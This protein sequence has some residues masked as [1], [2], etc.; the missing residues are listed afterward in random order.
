[1]NAVSKKKK[2]A[3]EPVALRSLLACIFLHGFS[4]FRWYQTLV[5]WFLILCFGVL[6]S[7]Y[8][9]YYVV[10]VPKQE[11]LK[12]YEGLVQVDGKVHY[13]RTGRLKPPRFYLDTANGK[14]PFHCGFIT[15]PEDCWVLGFT[16]E[17]SD[18][19]VRIAYDHYFGVLAVTYPEKYKKLKDGGKYEVITSDFLEWAVKHHATYLYMPFLFV[20]IYGYKLYRCRR[21]NQ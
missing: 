13:D 19:R 9:M 17:F 2:L 11:S 18:M 7:P 6:S 10:G 14:V 1:M 12:V 3:T 16:P 21:E 5:L 4:K 20:G 15:S 8:F